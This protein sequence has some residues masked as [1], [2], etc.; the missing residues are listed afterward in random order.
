MLRSLSDRYPEIPSPEG[1]IKSFQVTKLSRTTSELVE[2]KTQ[3][4]YEVQPYL[5]STAAV[6]TS[7]D[8]DTT[9][10]PPQVPQVNLA[11]HIRV[12]GSHFEEAVFETGV[13][14]WD[15]PALAEHIVDDIEFETYLDD[16]ASAIEDDGDSNHGLVQ[17]F[18]LILDLSLRYVSESYEPAVK[19]KMVSQPLPVCPTQST[20]PVCFAMVRRDNPSEASN[21]WPDALFLLDI[22]TDSRPAAGSSVPHGGIT[23]TALG[24]QLSGLEGSDNPQYAMESRRVDDMV[25]CGKRAPSKEDDPIG[26]E[27]RRKRQRVERERTSSKAIP[28]SLL[29]LGI[30][31]P[32]NAPPGIMGTYA[33][34]MFSALGNRRHLLV[35]SVSGLQ[36]RFWY[37]DRAGTVSTEEISITDPRFVATVLRMSFATPYDLGIEN[38]FE[39]PLEK[40]SDT[41]CDARQVQAWPH[42]NDIKGYRVVFKGHTFILDGLVHSSRC[43]YGRGTA[44][45]AAHPH[46]QTS[47]ANLD[48]SNHSDAWPGTVVLKL[49]WIPVSH[50]NG[51]EL[52]KLANEAG[53]EGIPELWSTYAINRLS[54]GARGRLADSSQYEDREL[55]VQVM[56]PLC[57]PLHEV[58]DVSEFKRA[59][60][61]LV[62]SKW[63]SPKCCSP[64]RHPQ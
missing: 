60:I 45:Y 34:E 11:S 12:K 40:L 55:R 36:G 23:K 19:M 25:K 64:G 27:P 1:G 33:L 16:Y 2:T 20:H 6:Q 47:S 46:P 14:D 50:S 43:L 32:R 42:F 61:S 54:R 49:S 62:K 28:E 8:E 30:H 24:Y 3:T 4:D 18:N 7:L 15:Y 35:I 41:E 31:H 9:G 38:S 51:G 48:M 58:D 63:F 17:L 21:G 52:F 57:I 39:A 56:T 37:F 29:K 53:V 5:A 10:R 22:Q 59:F 26:T 13:W 44:I